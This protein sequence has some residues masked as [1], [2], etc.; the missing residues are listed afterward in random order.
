M[1]TDALKDLLY[2]MADDAL[3]IAH[4][5]SEWT[6][7]GPLLEEDIAFSSIAQDKLGHAQ[8]LYRLLHDLGEPDPDTTAFMRNA[9][10]FH[11]C[12][13]VELPNGG[14]DRS[15]VRHVLFDAAEA[16][17]YAALEQSSYEPLAALARKVRGEIKYHS[18]H[19]RTWVTQLGANGNDE[20]HARLQAALDECWPYALGMFEPS[21][22]DAALI[23]AEVFIGEAAMQERWLE[24][25]QDIL[26]TATLVIPDGVDAVYGGRRGY[27]HESLQ[28]MLD[29]M[30]EVYRVDPSA[31]W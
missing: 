6:G 17:R 30:T 25:V 10:Q 26:G 4:R 28:P 18:F 20:S 14:Y 12:Q 15:L 16:L 19:A 27:H 1:N 8:A 2:R 7:L 22:H 24:H 9:A 21:D 11:S 5:H 23:A 29:E 13:L 3:I 31:E